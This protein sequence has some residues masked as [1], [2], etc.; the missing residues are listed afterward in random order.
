MKMRRF[1]KSSL[2]MILVLCTLLSTSA[3]FSACGK[4]ADEQPPE[5]PPTENTTPS[6]PE[7]E[8][9]VACQHRITE[10]KNART[11]SCSG[12][13]YTGDTVCT[14]CG[15]VVKAGESI[16]ALAHNFDAGQQTKAPT[17]LEPGCMIY[18]CLT[19]QYLDKRVV[20]ND[21]VACEGTYHDALDDEGHLLYCHTCARNEYGKHT[22]KDN[23]VP[24]P[25]T[26]LLPAYTLHTCKH[27]GGEYKEWSQS[28]L[29]FG[30]DWNDWEIEE[31]TCISTGLKKRT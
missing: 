14:A 17:C 21:G 19:C 3:I 10:L 26:C 29:S 2:A 20:S 12:A 9:L 4:K 6:S 15:A 16:P 23:G 24:Y 18:T 25:A 27:C 13:G 30:H 8:L 1:L 28:D 11:T 7:N 31:A 5:A 22:P